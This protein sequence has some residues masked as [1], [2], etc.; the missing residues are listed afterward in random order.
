MDPKQH[1]HYKMLAGAGCLCILGIILTV[2][3][4]P[5]HIPANRV[6]WLTHTTNAQAR[7]LYDQV[8]DNRGFIQYSKTL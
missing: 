2:G 3:L 4:W 7:I 6:H 1:I 5:F 8:A